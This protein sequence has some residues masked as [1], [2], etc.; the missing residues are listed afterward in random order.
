MRSDI[1][2]L[3]QRVSATAFDVRARAYCDFVGVIYGVSHAA[4]PLYDIVD[5]TGHWFRAV[6]HGD[7]ERCPDDGAPALKFIPWSAPKLQAAA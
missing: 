3:G 1:F 4:E 2:S 5:S 7:V 6:P